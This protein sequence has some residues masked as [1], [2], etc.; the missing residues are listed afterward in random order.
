MELII[1]QVGSGGTSDPLNQVGT[2]GYKM[3]FGCSYIGGT[4][5]NEEG[6]SPDLAY[7]I[8]GAAT[9]G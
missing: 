5:T 9:G 6:A 7:E 4:F 1:K 3:Q 8:R 2:A